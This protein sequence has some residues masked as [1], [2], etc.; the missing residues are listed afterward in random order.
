MVV[1][2]TLGNITY[3]ID[4]IGS[5]TWTG[6]IFVTLTDPNNPSNNQT[7]ETSN[8]VSISPSG[9][10]FGSTGLNTVTVPVGNY[11][12]LVGYT[13]APT[14]GADFVSAGSCQPSD[15]ANGTGTTYH[16]EDVTVISATP[17]E[18]EF[19]QCLSV[20]NPTVVI[21]NTLGNITYA[22]D[23]IG[24]TSWTGDI[25]VTLTD[26]N[27]PSN[28]QTLSSN[29]NVTISS[30]STYFGSTGLNTITV[31]V[32]NYRVLVGYTNAPSG[33]ADFASAGSCQPSDT[34]NGTGTTYHYEDV[35]VV[36]SIP[37][38]LE[39]EQCISLSSSTIETGTNLGNNTFEVQNIGTSSWTGNITAD[40]SEVGNGGNFQTIGSYNN[41]TISSNGYYFANTGTDLITLSPGNYRLLVTYTNA[42]NGGLDFVSAGTCTPSGTL[43]GTV[44]H[45]EDITI[46]AAGCTSFNDL[47]NAP[48]NIEAFEA[49]Q[50]LCS[51]GYITPQ[52]GNVNPD[53]NII[54]QDLAKLVYYTL[55]R[56]DA[57]SPAENFPVPFT[58]LN[59][60]TQPYY[61]YAKALCYLE[62]GDGISPFNRSGSNFYPSEEIEMRY[63]LKVILEAFDIPI[64]YTN[65]GTI[66]NVTFGDD[67][68]EYVHTAWDMGLITS[69][70]ADATTNAVR[71]NIFIVMKR[72]ISSSTTSQCNSE[73]QQD[74]W[75]L[76]NNAIDYFVP[77]A[78]TLNSLARNVNISEGYFDQ[79]Q[80]T[81]FVIPGRNMD[82]DFTHSYNSYLLEIPSELRK[83]CPLGEG[84]T[85][86]YNS[87]IIE[88]DG[89]GPIPDM[90]YVYWPDGSINQ[91]D[92]NT[93]NSESLGV[94]DI[95]TES[96]SNIYIKKKNQVEYRFEKS[97]DI[98]Y[99]GRIEDRNNNFINIEY[100][101]AINT[102]KRIDYVQDAHNRELYFFYKTGTDFIDRVWE[103]QGNRNIYFNVNGSGNL[104]SY[105][106]PKSNNTTYTYGTGNLNHYLET[107]TLPEGNTMDITY[108]D[109]KRVD[110]IKFPGI[111]Q[112]FDI[113]VTPNHGSAQPYESSIT[114]PLNGITTTNEFDD[115]GRLTMKE[116]GNSTTDITYTADKL[117]ETITFESQVTDITYDNNGNVL[118]LDQPLGVT[119]TYTYNS[120]NDITSYKDPKNNITTYTY[121]S[122]D[123]LDL[124][125]D[126]LGFV[127]NYNFNAS[128]LL[129]SIVNPENI[130]TNFN[131]DTYG[132]QISINQP[133]GITTTFDYD[134]ISRL[135]ESENAENQVTN[136]VYD[137]HNLVTEMERESTTGNILTQYSYNLNDNLTAI[138]NDDNNVTSMTYNNRDQLETMTFGDD[139]KTFEYRDDNLLNK[140]TRPNGVVLNYTYDSHGRITNDGYRGYTYDSRNNIKTIT[141]NGTISFNYDALDRITDYNDIY[142]KSVD[143]TYDNNSNVTQI[144]YPGNY[145]INYV[146]DDNNR[147]IEVKFNNNSRTIT[148][149][150]FND[151]R[152]K[153][154]TYPNGTT[155]DY[156]YDAAGRMTSI[157][158]KK[159]NNS[160]ICSY[161]Y[162]MDDLGNHTN[163][164]ATE[165]FT[166]APP[167][168]S[169][170][171]NG[172]YNGENET[173]SYGGSAFEHNANGEQ[174]KKNGR[175]LSF[176]IGGMITSNGN[177][178]YVY[179]GMKFMMEADRSGTTRR[180]TWDIRGIGNIIVE[181]DGSGNALYYYIHGHG[182]CARVNASNTNDIRYY[183]GDYR[184][185]TIAMTDQNQ[186]ITHQYQYLPYGE[187]SQAEEADTDNPFKYVGQWGVM[188]EG[189]N[190]Y[191]MR[192]RQYDAETGRF[193]SED[194]IWHD[195]LY[196][197][198]DNNPIMKLDVNGRSPKR[199]PETINSINEGLKG[200]GAFANNLGNIRN[201]ENVKLAGFGLKATSEVVTFYNTANKIVNNPD[202]GLKVFGEYTM[203]KGADVALSVASKSSIL[204]YSVKKLVYEPAKKD[205]KLMISSD[206]N[207][208]TLDKNGSNIWKNSQKIG[209]LMDSGIDKFAQKTGFKNF[210]LNMKK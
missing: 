113:N 164:T 57:P 193:L 114:N 31:P 144:E 26:P 115:T 81:S 208:N 135:I 9:T 12:V 54:R 162:T 94:F 52:N 14:G 202:D 88:Q 46:T 155:T 138:T 75:P 106:N 87:Y 187:I 126:N 201:L 179:D 209:N 150:Y 48:P 181:S 188:H 76:P 15:T 86:S 39:F 25:F 72:L 112:P 153:K 177:R 62:Y 158:S 185:S 210:I 198:A 204:S 195:N 166:G 171:Y 92:R 142:S 59:D 167:L 74:C 40:I 116:V 69:A 104:T 169:L 97:G 190:H 63:A 125:T 85:H 160:I 134:N 42:P 56:G 36:S 16:Y 200:L 205:I 107:I 50:C 100:E 70:S 154:L 3:A 109:N 129:T 96:G 136:Y 124:I 148:Y 175:S 102:S 147:L 145:D 199:I 5:T 71:K 55:Y 53:A 73:C 99:L 130:S 64:D 108:N 118:V 184:G 141:Y 18:L 80:K 84:W 60:A 191:Y 189:G 117:P 82:M 159:S 131:Y 8:N 194:P 28:N 10:Y 95:M 163:V 35:T 91:Y 152:L 83:V 170:T 143:Y 27:N 23:N 2:G 207:I 186:N 93:L 49:A 45:Y 11:R 192:A 132:N 149:T 168:T 111:N 146:Y 161:T 34:A 43:N 51:H 77:G 79:Y 120:L 66:Q 165:P 37:P 105:T 24:T 133:L 110:E 22:L 178:D 127:T 197:Y 176:D 156:G 21:N 29:T 119:H 103:S 121:D 203:D 13:N 38:E 137:V 180:Y 47:P 151:G 90:L 183:H 128:G 19:E 196:P 33:G 41:T 65:G 20:P 172:S 30:T 58:D 78:F 123:N 122:N 6:N 101:N 4:N 68:Y 157:V 140:Y 139:T 17:P 174:T 206:F 61:K 7:L 173:L 44:Y 89:S 32:G 1:N 67:A 98:W 182:L